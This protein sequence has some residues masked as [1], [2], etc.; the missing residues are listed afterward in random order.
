MS[1]KVY[2]IDGCFDGFHCGHIYSLF[3]SKKLCKVLNVGIYSDEEMVMYNKPSIFSYN[4]RYTMLK[5]CKYVDNIIGKVPYVL[6]E[7]TFKKYRC[8]KYILPYEK[9]HSKN[10]NKL[11]IVTFNG[12]KGISTEN[13]L[14]R[15]YSLYHNNEYSTNLDYIY[16]Y[17]ILER[18]RKDDI[19]LDYNNEVIFVH[20]DWD[21]FN[22][23]HVNYLLELKAVYPLHKIV[24]CVSEDDNNCVYN[25]LERAIIL[26]GISLIDKVLLFSEYINLSLSSNVININV[27]NEFDYI[28]DKL[29]KNIM[30]NILFIENR[31]SDE[32]HKHDYYKE[33]DILYLKSGKYFEILQSQYNI[34]YDYLNTI[35]F[36]ENDIII[37]DID[38]VCL[39]NLM[40]IN[41]FT[42]VKLYDNYDN[43]LFNLKNGYTPLIKECQCI[44]DILHSKNIKYSFITGRRDYIRKVTEENLKLVGLDKY[45]HLY[46]CPDDYKNTMAIFKSQCRMEISKKYNIVCCIGD[47][48]SDISGVHTGMPF[49]IF[50]P[51]Y[52]TQ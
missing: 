33:L 1:N 16:L 20:N 30:K 41:N 51:F 38:E 36:E 9:M 18:M 2:F 43:I 15:I 19:D 21:F 24:C 3:E 32:I 46:T 28:N 22:S 49:L 42:Y 11:D 5:Y 17:N 47:Q 25:H 35:Q 45:V 13:L 40:Y 10:V 52:T 4:E 39:S 6:S 34:I 50:N 27:S 23:S 14:Y 37:F 8:E 7:E 29:I 48:V 12:M 44:F 31:I 26:C